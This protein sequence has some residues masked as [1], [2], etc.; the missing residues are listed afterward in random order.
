MSNIWRGVVPI[1]SEDRYEGECVNQ[2]RN[3]KGK[4][5]YPNEDTYEGDWINGKKHGF[6]VFISTDK[7]KYE[8]Y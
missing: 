1:S 2:I 7:S 5:I 4:Y 3:G 6:G 8:G